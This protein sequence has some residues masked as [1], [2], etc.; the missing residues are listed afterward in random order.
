MLT[1][2][3]NFFLSGFVY[4]GLLW[5][6]ALLSIGLAFAFGAVWFTAYWTPILW[7]PWAW[8][9]LA[10][11]AFLSWTAVAFI[12]IPLQQLT[13]SFLVDRFGMDTYQSLALLMGIPTILLTGLVQEGSK[14]VPVVVVWWRK[15]RKIPPGFGLALGAVAGLGL[16]LLETVWAHNSVFLAG[17]SWGTVQSSGLMAL[18]PFWERFFTIAAHIAFSAIAGWGLAKGWGWQF[19]LIAAVLH[20]FLNYSVVL[21]YAGYFTIAA[22]EIQVAVIAVVVTAGAL[23]LRW[24]ESPGPAA[25]ET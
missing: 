11:S 12:Q 21:L 23:W 22:L 25:D 6:Q 3:V 24:G 20:A 15:G 10:G 18:A 16:G 7:R 19:Y 14:L 8:A 5:N 1:L 17:W 2:M 13:G 4:P 9:V